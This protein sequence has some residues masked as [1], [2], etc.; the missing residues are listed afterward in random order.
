MAILGNT[1][2]TNLTLLDGFVGNLNPVE[3]GVYDLGTSSLKWRTLY[4]NAESASAV[5]DNGNGTLTKFQYSASGMLSTSWL[6]SWDGYTLKAI[7]PANAVKSGIGTTAIGSDTKPVYWT[8]SA[9][10]AISSYEG[11]AATADKLTGF[12]SRSATM[13]WGNQTG[14]VITCFSTPGGGGW[15]FRDNNPS[16]GQT[17]M[18]ID[19]TV[20][21]KEGAINVGDAIKSITRNGTTFTYTTLWGNTGTFDQQDSNTTSFTITANATDGIWDI[22]GTNGTNAVTYAV[23]PY[24][25]QQSKASFDTGTTNPSRSDRLNYNGYLYAT[26]LYSG[27]TEVLTSHQSLSGYIPKSTLS[28]TYDIMYSSAASTPA[29]LAANTSATKKFL[30]MTG[31]GSAGAAPAWDTVSKSDVGLGNVANLD[32]S[33]AIK[34][35]TRNGTTFTYTALDGTTGTFSQQDNNTWTAMTGAT[36]SANGTV[37]YVNAVPPKDGYNTKYLRADGTWAVPPDNNTTYSTAT[38]AANGLMSSTDKKKL[39][40]IGATDTSS[41]IYIIG[42]TSQVAAPETYSDDQVYIENGQLDANVVRVA[43]HVKLQ[44]N[45]T[46]NALD[47]VFV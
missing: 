12:S 7:T 23:S 29:R 26:K 21:I 41:K 40:D 30:R 36:S 24:S 35:I 6:G 14:S 34:S 15:G 32:Q 22:T 1:K 31:T 20:Y 16:S 28:G 33:K 13:G 45:T 17:S 11:T 10:A 37:G 18:T 38:T 8:G 19:G 25:S 39:D 27:G 44:Y 2:A 9:F 43:T 3:T 5:K 4:G 47:F 42:A 46:T